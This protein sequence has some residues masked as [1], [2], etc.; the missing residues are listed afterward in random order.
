M[1]IN[2]VVESKL[3]FL[4][5]TVADLESWPLG[6]R[7]E[8]AASSMLRRAVERA[9]Q[10]GVESMIDVAERG[11]EYTRTI[12]CMSSAIADFF[13]CAGSSGKAPTYGWLL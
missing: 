1:P 9:L 11:S 2:G 13:Q 5:Q 7:A 4:E 8:F 3:R 6:D 10:L 12:M